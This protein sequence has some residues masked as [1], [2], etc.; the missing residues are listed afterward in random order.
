[1]SPAPCSGYGLTRSS[2]EQGPPTT[3]GRGGLL[4]RRGDGGPDARGRFLRR[5]AASGDPGGGARGSPPMR[6]S[7]SL[8]GRS[9]PSGAAPGAT[10]RRSSSRVS[11]TAR[12]AVRSSRQPSGTSGLPSLLPC[13]VVPAGP[14]SR[15]DGTTTNECILSASHAPDR[16]DIHRAVTFDTSARRL[17]R[18]EALPRSSAQAM[19]ET[20]PSW[21][22]RGFP[23]VIRP[24]SRRRCVRRCSPAAPT[25]PVGACGRSAP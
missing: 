15:L 25:L 4:R 10:T 2:R 9:S 7:R 1:M 13:F 12:A 18:G 11:P 3:R 5:G 19:G 23:G 17:R 24:R 8:R 20:G 22:P 21:L 6:S 16:R 14:Y